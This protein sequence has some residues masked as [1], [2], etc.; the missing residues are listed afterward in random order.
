[1]SKDTVNSRSKQPTFLG[2]SVTMATSGVGSCFISTSVLVVYSHM[3]GPKC[4]VLR[5]DAM[6]VML[7]AHTDEL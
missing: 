3:A 7:L 4:T 6:C 2:R 1:M 5:G